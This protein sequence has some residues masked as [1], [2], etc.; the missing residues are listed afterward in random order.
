MKVAVTG[1]AGFIG[2]HV[3]DVLVQEGAE[4]HIIDNL[5]S[6]RL[7]NV[8]PEAHLHVWDIC[9]SEAAQWVAAEQLDAVIHLAAQV[10]VQFSVRHPDQDALT[11]IVGTI[12]LLNACVKGSVGK[13]IFASSCAVYGDSGE[14]CITEPA[15]TEPISY[16]GLA[17]L[18]CEGYIRMFSRLYGLSH[19]ILRFSNVYGPRQTS[20]G[21]GGVVSIF[22]DKATLGQQLLIHGDGEQTRDFVFVKDVAKAI[23][24]A[25]SVGDGETIHVST[26]A[27]TSVNR[28]VEVLAS[29]HQESIQVKY[30]SERPGDIK[31]SWLS[32][33]KARHVLGWEPVYGLESGIKETY[34]FVK[35]E[36]DG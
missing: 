36:K 12:N 28:L 29:I 23:S 25:M 27:R 22:V 3:V 24:T 9:G 5:S 19:T 35:R 30:G 33:A 10:D 11:N 1:G 13:F 17:K 31:H 32:N 34:E 20:K 14:G 18:T 16:Y 4:V 7:E 2:S 26:A 6:G 15:K 21:E 8:H